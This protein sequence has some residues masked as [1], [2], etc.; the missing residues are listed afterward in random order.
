MEI[1]YCFDEQDKCYYASGMDNYILVS[2]AKPT[3]KELDEEV[4]LKIEL[5]Y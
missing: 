4:R 3:F 5:S 2:A 1:Q